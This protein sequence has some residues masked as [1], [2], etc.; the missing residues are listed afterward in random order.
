MPVWQAVLLLNLTLAI[1]VGFGYVV[2]GHRLLGLDGELKTAQAQVERLERERQACAAGARLG[3]QQWE[4]RGIVRA[5]Y[6]QLLLITHEEIAGLLPARTTGFRA[7]ASAHGRAEV[8]DPVR[9]WLQ[10]TG[11][12]NIVL[13]RMEPW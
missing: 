7:A 5:V 4:G 10:G 13:V 8:G 12:E 3:E 11:T 9:F 1:G 6:P 2:W